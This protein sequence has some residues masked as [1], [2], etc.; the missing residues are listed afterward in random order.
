M[1]WINDST[2]DYRLPSPDPHRF[3]PY[4]GPPGASQ[5]RQNPVAF[6]E[7]NTWS[8]PSLPSPPVNTSYPSYLPYEFQSPSVLSY[9]AYPVLSPSGPPPPPPIQPANSYSSFDGYRSAESASSQQLYNNSSL[10]AQPTYNSATSF[11]P[12]AAPPTNP[13]TRPSAA[14]SPPSPLISQA[15]QAA[16]N[17]ESPPRPPIQ[18]QQFPSSAAASFYQ[19][20][21]CSGN[22]RALCIG[23]DYYADA[24]PLRGCVNDAKRMREFLVS[25]LG[26][27]FHEILLLSE[28]DLNP[29]NKPTRENILTAMA[30]L[31]KDA[32][33]ND[34]LFFH[35]SG[36]GTQ[37]RDLDGDE[38]DGWDETIFPMDYKLARP[39][40]DDTIHD[41]L[42]KPLPL[43]CRL[44]SIFDSCHSGTAM[45]L[46]YVY[47]ANG[48]VQKVGFI[49]SNTRSL[50]HMLHCKSLSGVAAIGGMMV[51]G[52]NVF[53]GNKA[54][55]TKANGADCISFSACA[56]SGEAQDESK[57]GQYTGAMSF[58][59][60]ESLRANPTQS[61]L[62][63]LQ[64][65]RR[66]LSKAYKQVPQ[67]SS[68]HPMDMKLRFIA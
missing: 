62:E 51:A 38:E 64:D 60:R 50:G 53:A 47:N 56:D 27:Q 67:L 68:S 8:A 33:I 59:F 42:V 30:W 28:D 63:L 37:T 55:R 31:V 26:Y 21:Q 48:K 16:Q 24:Q 2:N 10:H 5:P 52:K 22:K 4:L 61:Y 14:S 15:A 49:S 17:A 35:F 1:Q 32:A 23:V 3:P 57:N 7:A 40:L 46:P 58:A 9:G 36:H 34:S 12:P 25:D 20:S 43:G 29:K 65:L 41:Y 54:R 13:A 39:I 18:Q 45:D 44:T 19:Y 66:R 11:Y 6:P